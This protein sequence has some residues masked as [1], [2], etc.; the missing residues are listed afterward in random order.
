MD[1]RVN[2]DFNKKKIFLYHSSVNGLLRLEMWFWFFVTALLLPLTRLS[3]VKAGDMIFS[4]EEI[5]AVLL[6]VDS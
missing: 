5:S 4:Q 6:L 1:R 3:I 2:K